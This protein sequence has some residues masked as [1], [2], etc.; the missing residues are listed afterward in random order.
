MKD[1]LSLLKLDKLFD[2]YKDNNIKKYGAYPAYPKVD[3][4]PDSIIEIINN[5]FI[6]PVTAEIEQ[7][8]SF[9]DLKEY[10]KSSNEL[11]MLKL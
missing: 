8:K 6:N 5:N 9:N 10:Y 1:D 11:I 7:I 2:Q 4:M 3:Y